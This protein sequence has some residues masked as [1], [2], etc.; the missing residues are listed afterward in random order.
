MLV[1]AKKKKQSGCQA[2]CPFDIDNLVLP[3]SE[4][5]IVILKSTTILSRY[6]P[7]CTQKYHIDDRKTSYE[8]I[9]VKQGRFLGYIVLFYR[10]TNVSWY[11]LNPNLM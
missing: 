9:L 6:K 11:V 10:S 1:R 7:I 3:P 5:Y 4:I 2:G 8:T